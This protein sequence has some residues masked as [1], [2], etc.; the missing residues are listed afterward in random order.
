MTGR[1]RGGEH[2]WAYSSIWSLPEYLQLLGL[3]WA[4]T[5][6]QELHPSLSQVSMCLGHQALGFIRR[7][8][9]QK[10]R[11]YFGV[12]CGCPKGPFNLL[13]HNAWPCSSYTLDEASPTDEDLWRS[14]GFPRAV[15]A[16]RSLGKAQL[17]EIRVELNLAE[18]F[19]YMRKI[20]LGVNWTVLLE[21]SLKQMV[22]HH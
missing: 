10:Q 8:M 17:W 4:E 11:Q 12:E 19:E 16:Q 20:I 21:N 6:S 7:K 3:A 18:E 5:K 14:M 1:K 2:T 9:D 22:G 15:H 13:H